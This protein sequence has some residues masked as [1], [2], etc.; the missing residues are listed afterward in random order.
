LYKIL[1]DTLRYNKVI[2]FPKEGPTPQDEIFS[3]FNRN[4][5][6]RF[7]GEV[8]DNRNQI[9]SFLP[10]TSRNNTRL[11]FLK[12]LNK[13]RTGEEID[14]AECRKLLGKIW[15][16]LHV[17]WKD[18]SIA[19]FS[20]R[21]HGI[22]YQLNYQFWRVNLTKMSP[23]L[24][25]CDKC[26]VILS[27]NVRGACPTYGCDGNVNPIDSHKKEVIERNH[28]HYLYENLSITNLTAEEHTAQLKQDEGTQVQN[29]FISGNINV[30]SCS[31]TFE[32]G[33][34]LGELETIFL[35]N[36]PPE[37]AN[38]IQRAGRAGRRLDSVGFTLTFAQLRSHDL[39]YF[40][41]PQKMVD[42]KIK[43][44]VVHIKNEKIVRRH[45]HSIILSKFFKDGNDEYFGKG[46]GNVDSFFRLE[47]PLPTGREKLREYLSSKPDFILESLQR[48]IPKEMHTQLGISDWEWVK[49]FLEEE[50]ALEIA[51]AKL[52]DEFENLKQFEDSRPKREFSTRPYFFDYKKVPVENK[53]SIG[54]ISMV[55][56]YSSS[57]ELAVICKGKKGGGFFVCFD[58]GSSDNKIMKR[59]HRKPNGD[60]HSGTIRGPLHLGHTFTTDVLS[61]LFEKYVKLET[62]TDKSFWLSLLYAILEG[63]SESLGI[64]RQDL[65]GC[66]HPFQNKTALV[67]FDNVPGG[68]GHVKRITEE[69]NLQDILITTFNR[70]KNCECGLETSCYSCLRNYQNQF[71]HDK[72]K[73]G[74]IVEF[75]EK[76]LLV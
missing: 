32:L 47:K 33:V 36:V 56:Q 76:N 64:R 1:L 40:K 23:N 25:S 73:R 13:K 53:F 51:E 5:E 9:Y 52:K 55:T 54:N 61:I 60:E 10:N 11:E 45:L 35:R 3:R 66:L 75:L 49:H 58:C 74:L 46:S 68:A 4:K 22:L 28:Y 62:P 44:P 26:G 2:T 70:V 15:N 41:E 69:S 29:N 39:T 8:S 50:N 21:R 71:C 24:F 57:G 19:L 48:S 7:R 67:L 17:N 6:Y 12:K 20:D 63:A 30:L 59:V 27:Q 34:D 42:G 14:N 31:T 43:P 65:D 16:D 38:Y 18:S 72:L 37:P